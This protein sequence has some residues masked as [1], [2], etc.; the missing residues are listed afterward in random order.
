MKLLKIQNSLHYAHQ[1]QTIPPTQYIVGNP[2]D[3][4]HSTPERSE[5]EVITVE[6]RWCSVFA[7][8]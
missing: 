1:N 4:P 7:L 3:I 5:G 2:S 8:L 6:Y